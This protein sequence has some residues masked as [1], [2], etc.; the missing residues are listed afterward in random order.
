[1]GNSIK[2]HIQ[3]AEKTGVCQL[4][5]MGLTEVRELWM[6][7]ILYNLVPRIAICVRNRSVIWKPKK[8]PPIF[9]R[10]RYGELESLVWLA[11]CPVNIENKIRSIK[12]LN[13][14]LKLKIF[15][16]W[17]WHWSFTQSVI[18]FVHFFILKYWCGWCDDNWGWWYNS[19]KLRRR[20][21]SAS[22]LPG[23]SEDDDDDV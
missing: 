8:P 6:I 22:E 3:N 12:Y 17:Q 11:K 13:E 23:V 20:W 19:R 9:L 4:C 2:P 18:Q 21:P 7:I 14:H 5:N 15:P 10:L 16:H 1:M